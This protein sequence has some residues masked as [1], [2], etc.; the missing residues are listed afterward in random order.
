MTE[1]LKIP[2]FESDT[3]EFKIAWS[4]T[5]KKSM[6][7]FLNGAGGTIYFGVDDSGKAVGV[8]R[9]AVDKLLTTI[10]VVSRKGMQPPADRYIKAKVHAVGERF[11]VAAT[12]L[13][14]PDLP[15][16]ATIKEEGTR[17]YV[18]RGPACF[19][20]TDEERIELIRRSDRRDWDV[21]PALQQQ[22]TFEET[23]KFF[24]SQNIQF[25]E[26]KFPILKVVDENGFYTN[27]GFLLSDQCDAE[28]RIG[29][30][31][32]IDKSSTPTNIWSLK[33]PIL[34]QLKEAMRILYNEFK[35]SSKIENFD[36]RPDG[37]R[38]EAEIYPKKAVREA[39]VNAFAHR[40][41]SNGLQ[42]FI[43]GFADR[44]EIF[45]FGG[46]PK[47]VKESQL[48]E[49]AS[50]CRNNA[51]ADLF[52]RL[53]LMER[54]GLGIPSMY[55]AYRSYGMRPEIL[56]DSNRIRIVLPKLPQRVANLTNDEEKVRNIILQRG[57]IPRKDIQEATGFSMSKTTMILNALLIKGVIERI[58]T[59]RNTRYQ[60][61]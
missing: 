59:G 52:W 28:T 13:P 18:R 36:L 26:R 35:Y 27:L 51:L 25:D 24:D 19:E 55:A 37:T 43:T 11:I 14:G 31:D 57:L 32:G 29:F 15:Y 12:V 48:E 5:A 44:L 39:M 50:A 61:K 53:G 42:A 40:D 30:F 45:T 7:A 56:I 8:P 23:K 16:Y 2:T 9:E 17:A 6:S 49:G 60:I 1:E 54:Y 4:E 38:E 58:G 33:G 22:L 47:G 10:A 3:A 41:Y 34:S 21:R 46:L 20:I